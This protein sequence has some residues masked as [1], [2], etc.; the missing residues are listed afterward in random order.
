MAKVIAVSN[1]KGGVGKSTTCANLAAVYSEERLRVL[2]IDLDPQA[3]LTTSLGFSPQSLP[4]TTY[5]CFKI[6][7]P[8]PL[9]S[10]LIDT[11]LRGVRLAPAAID[12]AAAEVELR[13]ELGWDRTLKKLLEPV[14]A[15]FDFVI[16]DCPPSLGALT[17]NA[18]VAADLVVVPIQAEFLA[19]RGASL[20]QDLIEK[21]RT[22]VNPN[23]KDR[24]LLTMYHRTV[25]AREVAQEIRAAFGDRLSPVIINKTVKFADSTVAG[26]P[27]VVFDPRSDAA[28]AYRQFAKEL[29]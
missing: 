16:V 26:T 27:L 18:L 25:H 2:L 1:Q 3:G 12:L 10:V 20:L 24:V 23:L 19:M 14:A 9:R 13:G 29:L 5:D 28:D 6:K 7:K 17:S 11:T 8:V 22:L 15:E 21:V 4:A